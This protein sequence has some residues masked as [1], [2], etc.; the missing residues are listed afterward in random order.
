MWNAVRCPLAA[1]GTRPVIGEGPS[2]ARV[3]LVGEAPGAEESRTG[4]P[5]V[6][7]AGR[8]L[9]RALRNVGLQ[10]DQVFI[11]SVEKYRPPG[12][13]PP[14]REEI[15]ACKPLL[16]AQLERI[17]PEIV[18]LMGRVAEQ[19][20]RGEPVLKG[21]RVLSTVHPAAAMRFPRMGQ[22][23]AHEFGELQKL[24]QQPL[25]RRVPSP[26]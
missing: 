12:N 16:L 24:A 6:G 26:R 19:A 1:E 11:T 10:R 4:R 23:F 15:D 18:V 21:R 13:R 8:F 22:R 2:D 5:F 17:D 9:D 14:R 20:L 25:S 3:F 7:A